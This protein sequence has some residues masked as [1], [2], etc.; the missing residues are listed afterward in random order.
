MSDFGDM[1]SF[2]MQ[3][4]R[5]KWQ[6]RKDRIVFMLYVLSIVGAIISI[7]VYIGLHICNHK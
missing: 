1:L 3:D 7:G 6:K 2:L 5:T 4:K